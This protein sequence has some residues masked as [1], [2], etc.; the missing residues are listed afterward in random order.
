MTHLAQGEGLDIKFQYV[1]FCLRNN[2]V[3]SSKLVK[4]VYEV[5]QGNAEDEEIYL[6]YT[7]LLF[8]SKKKH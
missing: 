4:I 3:N 7:L 2:V 5:L 6:L 8:S 1:K